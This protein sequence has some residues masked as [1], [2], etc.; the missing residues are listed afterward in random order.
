MMRNTRSQEPNKQSDKLQLGQ[1]IREMEA[2]LS[3]IAIALFFLAIEINVPIPF[4]ISSDSFKTTF[5]WMDEA[6]KV[7]K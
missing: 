3:W 5:L 2:E 4:E 6:K 1:P 7:S